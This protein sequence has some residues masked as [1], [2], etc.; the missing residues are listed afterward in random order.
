MS[1]VLH[2]DYIAA[3][4][5]ENDELREKVRVLEDLIG[6]RI[7][8]PPMFSLTPSEEKVLGLLQKREMATKNQIMYALYAARP[9]EDPQLKIIDVY[10]CKIRKKLKRFGIEIETRWGRG[11]ALTPAS[12]AIIQQLLTLEPVL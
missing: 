9:D 11:Y 7:E 1:D 5:A 12:K 3:I 6:S 2:D 10:I 8:A 4:E